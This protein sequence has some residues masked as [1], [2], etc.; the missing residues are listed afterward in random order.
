MLRFV[1]VPDVDSI[2]RDGKTRLDFARY[3]LPQDRN[4]FL[5]HLV[6]LVSDTGLCPT[7]IVQLKNSD[8]YEKY[9]KYKLEILKSAG[10]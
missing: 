1:Q 10:D 2:F 6:N 4:G 8:D 9:Y 7:L 5:S 3:R